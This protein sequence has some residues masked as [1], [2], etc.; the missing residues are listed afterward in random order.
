MPPACL[1]IPLHDHLFPGNTEAFPSQLRNI[2]SPVYL[3][4]ASTHWDISQ[5]SQLGD[6]PSWMI[7]ILTSSLQES[8][9]K[10]QKGKRLILVT[11]HR[12]VQSWLISCNNNTSRLVGHTSSAAMPPTYAWRCEGNQDSAATSRSL[13]IQGR[14][15]VACAHL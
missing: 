1:N 11:T 7:E 13:K 3:G 6:S 5:T 2:I 15:H 12:C 14:F 8:P 10:I 9:V 4:A